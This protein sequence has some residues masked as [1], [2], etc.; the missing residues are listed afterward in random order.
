M[1]D[2]R[3]ILHGQRRP[4]KLLDVQAAAAVTPPQA[5]Q[6]FTQRRFR[7]Y[8]QTITMNKSIL[9][10]RYVFILITVSVFFASGAGCDSSGGGTQTGKGGAGGQAGTGGGAAAGTSGGGGG[11]GGATGRGG[12]SGTAG[13]GQGGRGG[14]T[15][16][17][18]TGGQGA[19]CQTNANCPSGQVCYRGA[20]NSCGSVIAG[21]CVTR[22]STNC[23][24]T[25]GAGC[26]CLA[27]PSSTTCSS[28]G[29]YCSGSDEAGQ[30]WICKLPQ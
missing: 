5:A 30:C 21:T 24:Q 23:G 6:F 14:T 18:G 22:E 12:Q 29:A 20:A 8:T 25:T 13:P 7:G 27:L 15:G 11:S 4:G 17:G 1:F 10:L 19:T 3:G 26:P 28:Q 9:G 16:N 2:G